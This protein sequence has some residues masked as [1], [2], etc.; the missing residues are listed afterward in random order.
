[1]SSIA[2]PYDGTV[3]AP[4]TRSGFCF[5]ATHDRLFAAGWPHI[6]FIDEGQLDDEAAVLQARRALEPL[7]PAPKLRWN[8]RLATALVR[9]IAIPSVFELGPD[10]K[11]LR[12]AAEEAL[13]DPRPMTASEVSSGL[14]I[15]LSNSPM[16]VSDRMIGTWVLLAE[17]LT[18]TAAVAESLVEHL[19]QLPA[20][21]LQARWT[22]PPLVTY[23][24]G[25]LLLRLPPAA[26]G[27]L[28]SRV[29]AILSRHGGDIGPRRAA[30]EDGF[31]HLR[32]L[33]LVMAGAEA[34]R[35]GADRNLGWYTHVTDDANFVRMRVAMD[36]LGY[37]PDAR[38]VFLGGE[39]VLGSYQRRWQRGD[40]DEQRW[41]ITQM[42]PIRSLCLAP[43]M[44]EMATVSQA[45]GEAAQWFL[46]HPDFARSFLKEQAEGDGLPAG[47][48]R[49]L[50]GQ[51]G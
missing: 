3:A 22:L 47:Q 16:G 29:Q 27:A 9:A 50:L 21:M 15:R 44:L 41:F 46:S 34:A 20:P 40:S 26:S 38:L 49:K 43:V 7:D 36:R 23:Q 39:E 35:R 10:Q 51:I 25:Y 31:T 33:H 6:R 5:D 1:M 28:R 19:E 12:A 4:L 2:L 11:S 18:G 32:A 37:R 13:W 17:A 45:R 30:W 42:A 8:R 24:L 14:W 48:A